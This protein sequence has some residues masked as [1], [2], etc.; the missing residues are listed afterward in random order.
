MICLLLR[1]LEDETYIDCLNRIRYTIIDCSH[2]LCVVQVQLAVL[3]HHLN[4]SVG[5][6]QDSPSEGVVYLENAFIRKENGE[7]YVL[8]RND[9]GVL[10]KRIVELGDTSGGYMSQILSGISETDWIAFPYGKEAVEGAPAVEG[11]WDNLYG[12]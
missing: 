3:S 4:S 2:C 6:R 5:Q 12:Y 1:S 10:E 11:T 8:V 7:S 9:E